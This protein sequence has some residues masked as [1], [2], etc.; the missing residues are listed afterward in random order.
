[1]S[2]GKDT[3]DSGWLMGEFQWALCRGAW[4][5]VPSAVPPT[6]CV[7]FT[8]LSF[9]SCKSGA[10]NSTHLASE[11]TPVRYINAQSV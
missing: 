6:C 2:F 10:D 3:P 5:S 7:T 1:M 8:C 11:M 9:P 4:A